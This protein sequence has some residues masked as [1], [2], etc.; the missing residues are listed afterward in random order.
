MPSPSNGPR[1]PTRTFLGFSHGRT[2][3]MR[4]SHHARNSGPFE[5]KL[6]GKRRPTPMAILAS[7][8]RPSP[9]LNGTHTPES[10]SR[11]VAFEAV[12]THSDGGQP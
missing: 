1:P 6:E 5:V 12:L 2:E 3:T 7:G 9:Y 4:N 11:N 8:Q 10:L